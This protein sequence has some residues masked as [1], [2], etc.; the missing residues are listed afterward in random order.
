MYCANLKFDNPDS[1][2]ENVSIFTA[3]V[4]GLVSFLSPCVL[5]L[6]PGYI[7]II[8]GFT[9]DQLKDQ[10]KSSS[11]TRTVLL[12]SVMFIVGF[13]IT[14]MTLGASA[15]WL[16]ELL[17][18]KMRLLSEIAGLILIIFGLHLLGIFKINILYRDKRFHRGAGCGSGV[19]I[20]VDTLHRSDSRRHSNH[21][22]HEANGDGRSFPAW[23]LFDGSGTPLPHDQPWPESVPFL[24]RPIQETFSRCRNVQRRPRDCRWPA[25]TDQQSHTPGQLV[26]FPEPVRAVGAFAPE[27]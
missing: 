26:H 25:D 17:R 21:R 6:V 9:L 5:P 22:Q 11:L 27:A 18:S 13:S 12:N 16:G 3:F 19:R 7:S 23:Y 8:S 1:S 10:Q 20:W 15:T 24:L 4:A 2:Q 14:F